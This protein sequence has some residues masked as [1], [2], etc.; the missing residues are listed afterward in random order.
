MITHLFLLNYLY[1]LPSSCRMGINHRVYNVMRT[2][3]TLS[4]VRESGTDF[5][6]AAFPISAPLDD[7]RFWFYFG[8]QL[9]ISPRPSPSTHGTIKIMTTIQKTHCVS[10]T[11]TRWLGYRQHNRANE[12]NE[13][14]FIVNYYEAHQGKKKGGGIGHQSENEK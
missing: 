4:I 9:T 13:R 11:F 3:I 12:S 2:P 14:L 1:T 7:C 6:S 8:C 10:H 5:P